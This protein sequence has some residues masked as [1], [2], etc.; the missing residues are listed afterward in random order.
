MKKHMAWLSIGISLILVVSVYAAHSDRGCDSCHTPHNAKAMAGVPLWN[1][2]ATLKSFAG[3]MYA[4]SGKGTLDA[5]MATE[6]DGSSK[7]CLSCHDG[8]NTHTT[9]GKTAWDDLSVNH[10]ISFVY[11]SQ[12]AVKDGHL[13]DPSLPSGLGRTIA[14]DFLEN[15]KVQ[16]ISC[17][18]TH[19]SAV[20]VAYLRGYDYFHGTNGGALC[21]VCHDQ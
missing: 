20:G 13:K 3:K 17:H 9:M 6:P 2:N 18:D 1:G 7:L 16:C 8:T 5:T 14:E 19:K 10:P 21:R 4:D 11:D 12:L 15:G